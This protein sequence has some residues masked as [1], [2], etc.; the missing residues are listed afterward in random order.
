MKRNC[1]VQVLKKTVSTRA[2]KMSGIGYVCMDALYTNNI[3]VVIEGALNR[4]ALFPT[5]TA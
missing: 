4:C 2:G 5:E 3:G 1:M